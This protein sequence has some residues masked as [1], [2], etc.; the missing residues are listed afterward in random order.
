MASSLSGARVERGGAVTPPES[1]QPTAQSSIRKRKNSGYYIKAYI[2][3]RLSEL[4]LSVSKLALHQISRMCADNLQ[5]RTGRKPVVSKEK[6]I[7]PNFCL[8][9]GKEVPL[10]IYKEAHALIMAEATS[11]L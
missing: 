7:I 4:G 8:K 1:R 2:R 6:H 10:E 9:T 3:C 5:E 11:S